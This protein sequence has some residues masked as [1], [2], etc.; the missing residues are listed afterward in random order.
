MINNDDDRNVQLERN[1]NPIICE[2]KNNQ[3]KHRV[4]VFL[5]CFFYVTIIV[6][7]LILFFLAATGKPG[8]N[9]VGMIFSVIMVFLIG[10]DSIG[11]FTAI[12]KNSNLSI[13]YSIMFLRSFL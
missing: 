7:I 11:A 1:A 9:T 10:I 12:K 8:I 3:T 4:F 2:G 5:K 13:K 6:A